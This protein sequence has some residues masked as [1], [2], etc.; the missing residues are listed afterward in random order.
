M[1]SGKCEQLHPIVDE[2]ERFAW[3]VM[4]DS[5]LEALPDKSTARI[6]GLGADYFLIASSGRGLRTLTIPCEKEADFTFHG[7]KGALFKDVAV[8][9][10]D[11]LNVTKVDELRIPL[12]SYNQ[13]KCLRGSLSKECKDW[14]FK[15]GCYSISPYAE[16]PNKKPMPRSLA[17]AIKRAEGNKILLEKCR[18]FPK[19]D[20]RRLHEH[21]W[22]QNRNLS[23]FNMLDDLVT[24]GAAELIT[25][26]AQNGEL[27]GG[28]IDI[29]CEFSRHYYHSV[30]SKDIE[31]GL[32]TSILA[33][34]W[35]QYVTH[36]TQRVYSFGRGG[37]R[38]KF[39][40]CNGIHEWYELRGFYCGSFALRSATN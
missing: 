27:L 25:A 26:R 18:Q 22:G 15:F 2:K 10:A 1:T 35:E 8:L 9:L 6:S 31:F 16:Y 5:L 19:S 4:R 36:D 21:M 24:E 33:Y 17:R 13:A 38:Y 34:S 12:L 7:G 23:F 3:K 40:Y 39:R 32:G 37:E 30:R 29:P 11:L 14:I 28:Q 20:Y